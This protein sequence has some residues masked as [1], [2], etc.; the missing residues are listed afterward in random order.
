[1]PNVLDVVEKLKRRMAR[2]VVMID[3]SRKK[4][5]TLQPVIEQADDL[6]IA[7]E[8]ADMRI[9]RVVRMIGNEQSRSILE[10]T[11]A[12]KEYLDRHNQSTPSEKVSLWAFLQEYLQIVKEARV[13]D[14]VAFLQAVGIDYAQRQTIESVIRRKPREFKI[15]KR[16]GQKFV[17]LFPHWE[18]YDSSHPK[19]WMVKKGKKANASSTK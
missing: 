12:G 9:R 13:G 3:E 5:E 2:D 6:R 17:S 10:R 1:M 15:T 7:I 14:I 4:L 8:N 11:L 18:E 19:E 16:D